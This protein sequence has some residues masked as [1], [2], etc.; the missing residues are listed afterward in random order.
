MVNGNLTAQ[1]IVQS[2]AIHSETLAIGLWKPVQ[3]ERYNGNSKPQGNQSSS[4]ISQLLVRS[5]ML[6]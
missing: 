3:K 1:S 5:L 6:C 2:A 4:Q